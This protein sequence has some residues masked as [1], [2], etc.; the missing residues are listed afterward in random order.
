MAKF[1]LE[2]GDTGLFV[3][4][5]GRDD[6]GNVFELTLDRVWAGNLCLEL[7]DF[8]GSSARKLNRVDL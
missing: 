8:L 6:H 4:M 5:R 2:Q 3:L 1:K 7:E